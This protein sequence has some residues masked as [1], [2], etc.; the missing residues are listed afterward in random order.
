M[1]ALRSHFRYLHS[2]DTAVVAGDNTITGL[3]SRVGLQTNIK[4]TET[5]TFLPGKIRTCLTEEG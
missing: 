1:Y 2:R 3:F 5:M 4:K